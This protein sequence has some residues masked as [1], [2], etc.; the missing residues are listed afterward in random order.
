MTVNMLIQI[1]KLVQLLESPV[2]TCRN[3]NLNKNNA[4]I[5]RSPTATTRAREAPTLV[6]VPVRLT[7]ASTTIIS[8]R[9]VEKSTEQCQRYRLSSHSTTNVR[10]SIS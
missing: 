3:N 10:I 2:F 9:R 4:D 7:H 6:Q 5:R 8:L 1:D